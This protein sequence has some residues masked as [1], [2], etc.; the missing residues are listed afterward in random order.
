[1]AYQVDKFN[2]TFLVSV[3][4]GTVDTITDIQLVGKNYAGY[5]E[6]QNENFVHILE[7][8]ANLTPPPKPLVGQ[9]WYDSNEK[10]L[11]CYDGLRFKVAAAA[12]S[13][14]P[15]PTGV[16]IGDFW[17]DTSTD[18]LY[19]W[20]GSDY[21][22]V[23]PAASSTD[24]NT[25]VEN[26]TLKDVPVIPGGQS[27]SHPVIAFRVSGKIVSIISN[28]DFMIDQTLTPTDGFTQIKKG[29]N[30]I[31]TG[32]G[33]I[34]GTAGIS[35]TGDLDDTDDTD[36][37][38]WGTASD[39]KQLGGT[40]AAF[41]IRNDTPAYFSTVAHFSN[42]GYTVG[43]EFNV[44]QT[45]PI[46]PSLWLHVDNASD[47]IIENLQ[48]DPSARTVFRKK[49]DTLDPYTFIDIAFIDESG[50]MPGSNE[51]YDL[52]ND[53]RRWK[54]IYADTVI[55]S[56]IDATTLGGYAPSISIPA[57]P[58]T[59]SVVVR[60][61]TGNIHATE[62]IGIAT[63]ARFAD[64]AEKYLT[65]EEYEVGT[66]VS[67]GG[68]AEVTASTLGDRVIGVVSANPAFMMNSELEGGTYIALKGR[69]PVKVIG[70]VVKGQ[71]LVAANNGYAS[72]GSH[73][74]FAVALETNEDAG[75]KVVESIIL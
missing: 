19:V 51:E 50:F 64:L 7:N 68:E 6:I 16:A 67:V 72:V 59:S 10:K 1:M 73:C 25:V 21:E 45:G 17:W 5:G 3:P 38:Y 75:E 74:V 52:G 70:P 4:D 55:G 13:T 66:V 48:V 58:D 18:Q 15:A 2:G 8:F 65:D 29:V 69:V 54:T 49:M 47:I 36:Y 20:A 26:L 41:Y 35:Y 31:H 24:G 61:T 28:S 42:D 30:L 14:Q 71:D 62:F 43:S 40:D 32:D 60:D 12:D 33:A 56:V 46:D 53:I 44:E 34:S 11:K 63:S 57:A 39:S 27:T 22:L 23:G 9:T 37:I